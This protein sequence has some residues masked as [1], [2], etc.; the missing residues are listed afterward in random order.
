[1]VYSIWKK[2]QGLF[3]TIYLLLAVSVT[4]TLSAAESPCFENI[5][6]S[7]EASGEKD[8]LKAYTTD[9]TPSETVAITRVRGSSFSPQRNEII[10]FLAAPGANNFVV[11]VTESSLQAAANKYIPII[12]D[13]ILLKLLN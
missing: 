1:M 10:R 13:T 7:H 11:C 3:F 5:I 8:T 12:K 6:L 9:W 2:R 4:F